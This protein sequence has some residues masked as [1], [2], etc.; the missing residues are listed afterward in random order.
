MLVDI[1]IQV[2]ILIVGNILLPVFSISKLQLYRCLVMNFI[3]FLKIVMPEE[4]NNWFLGSVA[5]TCDFK[6]LRH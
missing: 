1:A 2:L 4:I 3:Y 6:Y 5:D